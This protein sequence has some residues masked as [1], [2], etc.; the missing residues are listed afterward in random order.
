MSTTTTVTSWSW[1]QTITTLI[2]VA[3]ILAGTR[4]ILIPNTFAECFGLP[5]TQSQQHICTNITADVF[6]DEDIKN[7][8]TFEEQYHEPIIPGN[9]STNAFIP[10]VGVRNITV[11]LTLLVFTIRGDNTDIG[12]VLLCSLVAMLGDSWVCFRQGERGA[13]RSHVISAVGFAGMGAYLTM[14]G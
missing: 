10:L 14:F 5:Q 7:T 3:T 8:G 13:V 4:A 6:Q 9:T 2:S 12:I 11:G 1:P